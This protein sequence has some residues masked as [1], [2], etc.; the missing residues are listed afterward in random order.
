MQL[1][2]VWALDQPSTHSP[3]RHNARLTD[4]CF[5][6]QSL[7]AKAGVLGRDEE[8]TCLNASLPPPP[9]HPVTCSRSGRE[10]KK[11][12]HTFS[13]CFTSSTR[14]LGKGEEKAYLKAL[15]YF[16]EQP[17]NIKSKRGGPNM[18]TLLLCDVITS[19]HVPT[20]S[21]NTPHKSPLEG[22]WQPY[23]RTSFYSF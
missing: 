5:P 2:L 23:F 14:Q 16:P 18:M 19:E 13:P 8:N 21:W 3:G 1:P 17:G 7:A 20:H 12:K 9:S 4:P 22:T 10:R 15:P 11:V 6:F